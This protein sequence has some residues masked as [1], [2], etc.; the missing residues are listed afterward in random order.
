[1]SASLQL[2]KSLI[3]DCNQHKKFKITD[4]HLVWCIIVKQILTFQC[5]RLVQLVQLTIIIPITDYHL[6]W[7]IIL[8]Q[9]LT[10]QCRRLVQLVQLTIIIP[11]KY[12]HCGECI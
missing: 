8:K 12:L 3:F 4:Y 10:F 11:T 9:I 1:M 2:P 5:R 6:V 7:S